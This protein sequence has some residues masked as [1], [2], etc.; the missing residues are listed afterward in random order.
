MKRSNKQPQRNKKRNPQNLSKSLS[1]TPGARG[2]APIAI[3]AA[4]GAVM[5][6]KFNVTAGS[7]SNSIRIIGQD[8]LFAVP[9]N[10]LDNVGKVV[11]NFDVS[12]II[13]GTRLLQFAQ[14]Y[15][16]YV[17][18]KLIFHYVPAVGTTNSGSLIMAFDKDCMDVTPSAA[19]SINTLTSYEGAVTFPIWQSATMS[20][21]LTDHQKFYYCNE[22]V[23]SDPR[24]VYQ[25]QLYIA[26]ATPTLYT[27]IVGSIW[28]EYEIELFDPQLES[29][30]VQ[31][32]YANSVTAVTIP[33]GSQSALTRLALSGSATETGPI[34][35]TPDSSGNYSFH[36]PP[37]IYQFIQ[38]LSGI[39]ANTQFNTPLAISDGGIQGATTA[40]QNIFNQ[41]GVSGTNNAN[42]VDVI[43]VI[44]AAA[45]IYSI[46]SST[47]SGGFKAVLSPVPKG[48]FGNF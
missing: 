28:M 35:L 9:T 4:T 37:G 12:P 19:V 21:S 39:S 44:G 40:V 23:G 7:F 8:Y 22:V 34:N 38:D 11:S 13:Q 18:R 32:D 15:D 27:G 25:G 46:L 36:V 30:A 1:M 45:R 16:K 48:V 2:K 47:S 14:L 3:P 17:F 29:S 41:A 6:S 24:L 31:S 20:C 42:R 5:R 43:K 26:E 10:S 33:A